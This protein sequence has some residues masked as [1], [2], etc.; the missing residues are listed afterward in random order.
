MI[1]F[2]SKQ[3]LLRYVPTH[4]FVPLK[5]ILKHLNNL[6]E[7]NQKFW[8]FLVNEIFQQNSS[9]CLENLN[10]L[11]P[12]S[13]CYWQA[14]FSRKCWEPYYTKNSCYTYNE[15]YIYFVRGLIRDYYLWMF[16]TW[17]IRVYKINFLP[18]ITNLN[19]GF[20]NR[21]DLID[22]PSDIC[23]FC[24][25]NKD[26][27]FWRFFLSIHSTFTRIWTTAWCSRMAFAV[28]FF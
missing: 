8:F 18:R 26:L 10:F 11:N 19:Q 7:R 21:Y 9:F 14:Y 20:R 15:I 2:Y 1:R 5:A 23:N 12:P 24:E 28:W 4:T 13:P 17:F 6:K 25:I 3:K 22:K 16:Y 27:T